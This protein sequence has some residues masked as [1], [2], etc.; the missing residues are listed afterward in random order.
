MAAVADDAPK[1]VFFETTMACRDLEAS[2]YGLGHVLRC[3]V[4]YVC[5]LRD[6]WLQ[7]LADGAPPHRRGASP[8]QRPFPVSRKAVTKSGGGQRSVVSASAVRSTR[9]RPSSLIGCRTR[10]DINTL[11]TRTL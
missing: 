3:I 4:V 7:I 9:L 8:T 1:Q 6:L 5:V 10:T 11:T 2:R